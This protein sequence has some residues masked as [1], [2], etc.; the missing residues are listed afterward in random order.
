MTFESNCI[1]AEATPALPAPTPD[2]KCKYR[3][4]KYPLIDQFYPAAARAEDRQGIVYLEFSIPD[5]P[6]AATDIIVFES[7]SH[8]DIDAAGIQAL[9]AA[10]FKTNCTDVRYRAYPCDRE[11]GR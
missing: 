6:G 5:S 9:G 1:V 4:K 11:H 10:T 2:R 3:F 7:S 8:A